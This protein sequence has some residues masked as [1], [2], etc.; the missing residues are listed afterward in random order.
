MIALLGALLVGCGGVTDSPVGPPPPGPPLPPPPPPPPPDADVALGKAAF[1]QSCSSCHT[2]QDGFD[3]AYF[4]YTDTTVIRRAVKHVDSTTAHQIVAYIRSL[5][6]PHVSPTLRLFQ[7]GGHMVASDVEFATALFGQDV[8]P[9]LSTAQLRA[10]DPLT[11]AVALSFPIWSDEGSNMDWL[12]DSAPP[13]GIVGFA[14]NKAGDAI[15]AYHAAPSLANL[16]LAVTALR[17]ADRAKANPSA[18]CVFS[19]AT[20]V[21]Y[22]ACFEARRWTA[23]LIAQHMLRNG[24][25][26]SI[27]GE[28]HEL[29]WDVGDA[30]RMAQNKPGQPVANASANAVDWL[31][32]GWI[33]DPSR[34]ETFYL[35]NALA[36]KGL[37]RHAT[38]TALRSEVARPAGSSAEH[39][40]VYDDF[41]LAAQYAPA[42]WTVAVATFGLTHILERLNGGDR[43]TTPANV[44][45]AKA[46]LSG[47]MTEVAKKVSAAELTVIQALA[48]Q[49]KAKL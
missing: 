36:Q 48:D 24:I 14:G 17:D 29:W 13:A 21:N 6:T 22:E 38:F 4:S 30:A 42:K 31:Y 3:L 33:F 16:T 1:E 9:A 40:S 18:P 47:G 41:R 43:P 7:P 15:T 28:L 46:Q 8:W 23:T 34:E 27:G 26:Q 49:I 11:T 44:T 20:R 2:A 32:L 19:D 10:I 35:V 37:V 12:P 45:A 25:T 5:N 39:L